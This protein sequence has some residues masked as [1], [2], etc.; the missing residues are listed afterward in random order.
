MSAMFPDSGVPAVD[1]RNT[2]LDP[3]TVNCNELWYST[4]RCTPRFD[5]AAANAQLSE[6]I[7]AINCA[8]IA[9]DCSKLDNLCTAIKYLVQQGDSWCAP[10]TLG[11][12]DY[13]GDLDPPLLA[14]PV[15]NCCMA[16][17]VIPNV[18]NNDAPR[19]NLN[20]LGFKDVVRN[21]GKP[22][23][24]GDWHA[25]IPTIL[26]YCN[27]QWVNIGY[28]ESQVTKPL[29]ADL[30][31][32]VNNAIGS[33]DPANDGLSNT[34]GHALKTFQRAVDIAYGYQAGG[35]FVNIHIMNGSGPYAGAMTPSYAGPQLRI[36]GEGI[37]TRL[38][39]SLFCFLVRGPNA[40]TID[41]VSVQ[42]NSPVGSGGAITAANGASLIISNIYYQNCNGG[43][44]QASRT[45]SAAI[46]ACTYYGNCYCCFYLNLGGV[47]DWTPGQQTVAQPISITTANLFCGGASGGVPAS[48]VPWVGAGNVTGSKYLVSACGA[49]NDQTA[50]KNWF[51]GS[52]AGTTQTNGVYF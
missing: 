10:L 13:V 26:I 35:H 27:G 4:N 31:L 11:P 46:Y 37:N 34:V 17:K 36:Y 22:L 39:D 2:L 19:V 25:N 28:V 5:P 14:Y 9:Y 23:L 7:N 1:A 45:G 40:A 48:A 51:A 6:L 41:N 50:G 52:V 32:W 3:D 30:D 49:I 33:D 21:D 29:N 15:D 18:A 20:G 12:V 8:G 38:V 43:C 47:I 16:V 44:M 42:Q 24:R